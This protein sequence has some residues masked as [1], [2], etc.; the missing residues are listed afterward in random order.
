MAPGVQR[1]HLLRSV[2]SATAVSVSSGIVAGLALSSAPNRIIARWI[3][4]NSSDAITLLAGT[5]LLAAVSEI[6]CLVPALCASH[7]DPMTALRID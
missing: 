4:N 6:A 2:F 1:G 3:G 7:I 5:L